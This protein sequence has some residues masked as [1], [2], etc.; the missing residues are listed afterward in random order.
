[1]S[2]CPRKHLSSVGSRAE[3]ANAWRNHHRGGLV[4]GRTASIG[5]QHGTWGEARRRT[6]HR[7][8]LLARRGLD[9]GTKGSDEWARGA[10]M[11]REMFGF[12]R[13]KRTHART[14][15]SFDLPGVDRV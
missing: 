2:L 5:S 13:H 4:F 12:W 11:P 6:Y 8:L 10:L 1:M 9:G 14:H 15:D 3:G 7:C